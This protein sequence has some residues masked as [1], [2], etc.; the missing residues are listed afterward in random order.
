MNE[1]IG[2]AAG[3]IFEYLQNQG[4]TSSLK[5]KLSL[6]IT[7]SELFLAVGWLC[8]EGKAKILPHPEGYLVQLQ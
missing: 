1:K 7:S 5:L 6:K 3:K 4:P 8:R 2:S